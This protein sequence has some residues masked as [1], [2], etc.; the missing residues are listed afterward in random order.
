[1]EWQVHP[2]RCLPRR[3][4]KERYANAGNPEWYARDKLL[5]RRTGDH[6]LAAVDRERR[7][8]SNNFFIVF[9]KRECDLLLDGLC[10]LLNSRFMTWYFRTVEPRQGR[11]FAELKIKHLVV[12]PLPAAIL[13]PLGCQALNHL[14][15]QR[16]E[17]AIQ[18]A[19][20][21]APHDRTVL[22]A[23]IDATDRQIDRLVY[24]LYG[25]AEE[26]IR[27]VEASQ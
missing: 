6:V 12:F 27:I 25:L 14:G 9:P 26:E 2:A 17:L 4:T 3:K 20:A 8:A 10:A 15:E 5:V 23:Q 22:Q 11:V 24:D 7:Y 19:A 1:M 13:E 18:S 21:K 16:A